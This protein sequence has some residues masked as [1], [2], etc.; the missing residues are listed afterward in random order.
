MAK[1]IVEKPYNDG[2][3]T[4]TGFWSFIRSTLRRKSMYWK[5]VSKCKANAKRKYVGP[6]KRQKFEYQCNKCKDW[7]PDK[8]VAIDHI[9]EVGTLT[10]KED[11]P[12]FVSRLFCEVDGLQCLCNKCH[13]EKTQNFMQ[14]QRQ[15]KKDD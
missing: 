14:K 10:C 4:S 2:T 9:V 8:E 1:R 11:L 12:D 7:F 6:N 5:P 3:M 13:D 15:K